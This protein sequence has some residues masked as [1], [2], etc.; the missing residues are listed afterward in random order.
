[1]EIVTKIAPICLAL[2]ML[3]LGLGLSVKDFTRILRVPKD[4]FV[5][6]FSQLVI[7]PIVALGIALILNLPA[8]IAVGLM[9]IAAA[10]GGV[11][12]NVLTKFANG[13]VALS[14]SL[15][16][17][18]SLI[19][20]VSVPFVVITS[21]DILGVSISSDISMT[22]IALKMALVV[23]VPVVIGMT[24]RG[25]AENFISSKIN[26]INKITGWL[27][28]IVFAAI[29][30]EEKDNILTYLA[31]AGLAV[32]ILNVIMMTIA[33]FIAKKFVSGIAQQKCVALECGL[34]NGTL[35]VFVATLMFDDIAYMIPTAA[36]ALIMY[37]TGFIFIYIL[38]KS[39]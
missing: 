22:G 26:I 39:S 3:G 19:S 16:A 31:E 38:R 17:I 27:F 32:L 6:F 9:I 21:A 2:I 7:L 23:T 15:T 37:I 5:G 10:P 35:A 18:V 24:I 8:P 20:I 30:I 13:D 25:F 4:F 1:M 14:I 34:Q 29:W 28:V 11:T 12:S 33:Y 36:Y